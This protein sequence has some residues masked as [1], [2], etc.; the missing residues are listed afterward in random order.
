MIK[1]QDCVY[2]REEIG[3]R[4][5]N[6]VCFCNGGFSFPTWAKDLRREKER[7]RKDS[8]MHRNEKGFWG[9][10]PNQLTGVK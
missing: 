4:E 2:V 8:R 3:R 5:I 10:S 6:Q 1:I 9:G 7:E